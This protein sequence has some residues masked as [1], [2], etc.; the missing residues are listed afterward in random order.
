MEDLIL[1][2]V[3]QFL[4]RRSLLGVPLIVGFS[5]GP[6]SLAL[7]HLLI[8]CRD[9]YPLNLHIAHIDHRWRLESSSQAKQLQKYVEGLGLPFHLHT[10][11][12]SQPAEYSSLEEAARESRLTFFKLL[13]EQLGAQALI[14]AHQA[15]D[16]AETVLKRIFEGATLPSLGG[17]RS[18]SLLR[19]MNVWRPLL[20]IPKKA[21][22]SW[23]RDRGLDALDD[24]SNLWPQFLRARTRLEILPQLESSF[25][26]SVSSHL[27]RLGEAAQEL[28]E[29]LE[30]KSPLFSAPIH[31][32]PFGT[33]IDFNPFYPFEPVELRFFLKHILKKC[34]LSFEAIET[35]MELLIKKSANR[36]VLNK[37]AHIMIDRGCLFLLNHPLPSFHFKTPLKP[38]L[39]SSGLW[40][41]KVSHSEADP[42]SL[43]QGWRSLWSG[44]AQVFL[45]EGNYELVPSDSLRSLKDEWTNLKIPAFFRTIFPLI[46]QNGTLIHEFLTDKMKIYS[47]P[48]QQFDIEIFFTKSSADGLI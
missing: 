11:E 6:D 22:L 37:K 9:I 34:E 5:G 24:P 38:Q 13:Y 35:L 44:K 23:I 31:Q 2:S 47:Q 27:V 14:L 39:L 40:T 8:A 46:F 43:S 30:A 17:M 33:Y 12:E 7:L 21:L 15:D 42:K 45:P 4:D 3:K 28:K 32:G 1:E 26:K 19:G 41:W 29:Y 20:G 25:G 16:Q 18:C 10:L 36:K 48:G